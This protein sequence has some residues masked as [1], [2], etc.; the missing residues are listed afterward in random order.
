MNLREQQYLTGASHLVRVL[1]LRGG[2]RVVVLDRIRRRR[3]A[4]KSLLDTGIVSLMSPRCEMTV[5][6]NECKNRE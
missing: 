5:V 4:I 6:L 3:Q 2:R 1:Y